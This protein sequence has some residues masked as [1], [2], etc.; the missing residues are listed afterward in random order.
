MI[1]ERYKIKTSVKH[2]TSLLIGGL[3]RLG[4]EIADSLIEQGG[5][6]IIIDTYSENNIKALD[7]LGKNALVSFADYT[8]LPHLEEELRRLDYVF[9]FIKEGI[10]PS[11]K[12]STQ[13]F[14]NFSN[15]LDASLSL[16]SKFDAK[17][18]LS[19]TIKANQQIFL[20]SELDLNYGT[21]NKKNHVVY[22]EMELQRYAE[23]LVMEYNEKVELD[24]RIV[25]VGEIIGDALDFSNISTF[26]ELVLMAAA[27][28]PIALKKDG[29]E[30]EWLVHFLDAAY[31]I[32]KAQ[33][34]KNTSGKIYSICYE[35]SIT[36]LGIAYKIQEV[37][38][39]NQEITFVSEK[40]SLPSLKLY[41]PAPNLSTI[42]WM[43]RVPF[44]KAI[45]QSLVA[46]RIFLLEASS[47][48]NK[49]EKK[50]KDN[51]KI[52][53]DLA[54]PNSVDLGSG[55]MGPITKLIEERKK[56]EEARKQSIE[57]ANTS[58]KV[59]RRR[60]NLSRMEKFQGAI[61]NVLINLGKTFS[62]LKNRTPVE[63]ALILSGFLVILWLYF[64]LISPVAV[65]LKHYWN[66]KS[67]ISEIELLVQNLE[68]NQ[69]AQ[70]AKIL[71]LDLTEIS[72]QLEELH[73][74][75]GIIGF[76][77]NIDSVNTS[78]VIYKKFLLGLENLFKATAP[79]A[80]YVENYTNN[81]Q[82]R[83][84]TESFLSA[85]DTGK[86]YTGILS[87]ITTNFPYLENGISK[88]QES[89]SELTQINFDFI[90]SFLQ[91]DILKINNLVREINLASASF[92]SIGY[93][94]E[95]LG[96]KTPVNV[97]VVVLDNTRPSPLGGSFSALG[98][99]SL[100]NGSI[101]TSSFQ[102]TTD[103]AL[104]LASISDQDL[105]YINET[106]FQ[107]KTR[108]NLKLSDLTSI[109]SFA[110]FAE[111][112][113]TVLDSSINKK[114]DLVLSINLT[115]LERIK[116]FW[117]EPVEISGV[118]FSTN[119]IVEGLKLLSSENANMLERDRLIAQLSANYVFNLSTNLKGGI[120]EF[121]NLATQNLLQHDMAISAPLMGY[122]KYV[123]AN[124]LDESLLKNA[125][126]F[127][128]VGVN[129]AESKS[130]P[131]LKIPSITLA[132][133]TEIT[134][135]LG[136]LTKLN[137]RI[138]ENSTSQ[139]ISVCV[140]ALTA[141]SSISVD[142]IAK[143]RVAINLSDEGKCIVAYALGENELTFNWQVEAQSLGIVSDT[144]IL[145]I[146]GINKPRG[147]ASNLD[148]KLNLGSNIRVT[149]IE[150][151]L[152]LQNN[153]AIFTKEIENDFLIFLTFRL[154]NN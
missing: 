137:I 109:N 39:G 17:F 15:Y 46:A 51:L 4:V 12:I 73:R 33:F 128:K 98:I 14:L 67:G 114:I 87:K 27:G 133:Q 2:P 74:I 64:N 90:P 82:Y 6:V 154:E 150:P 148:Y 125:A 116:S 124:Y 81:L 118:N 115:G 119:E 60:K 19:T 97:A 3:T 112:L 41:K 113:K 101:S 16:A 50:T 132:S 24:T 57:L 121:I 21:N 45:K 153:T 138:P 151:F 48:G 96:T 134:N 11:D 37:E 144:E 100:Q 107:Y 22:T 76:N 71:S 70:K 88:I 43:P 23:S 9:Y 146:M 152:S 102:A 106:R 99:L 18:L 25:R 84:S 85:L 105:R 49:G 40:D 104:D 72:Y 86:D 7:V 80:E 92:T 30:S 149:N 29:L 103:M 42:G 110:K 53:V 63:F 135:N 91:T 129:Q 136:V 65:I 13:Q 83:Y 145:Y 120:A 117:T 131:S 54:K 75:G 142:G 95:L 61:W 35:N 31:G 20:S 66:V 139:E 123:K 1:P 59:K 56:Q 58:I 130:L 69:I 108:E 8:A 93:L 36:H 147:F 38:D 10:S 122:G 52:F 55:G 34:S 77:S 126:L 68:L 140:P 94:P 143:E 78:I 47:A 5:Y 32:V 26:S 89:A 141:S 44:D 62:F 28:Q 79:F 111:V 127:F